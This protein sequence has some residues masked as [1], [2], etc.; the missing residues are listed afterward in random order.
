[1]K[2][3][4]ELTSDLE[5][6]LTSTLATNDVDYG[7]IDDSIRRFH[8]ATMTVAHIN[9]L[10]G[11]LDF[12]QIDD[13]VIRVK[14]INNFF[15]DFSIEV[16]IRQSSLNPFQG[17]IKSKVQQQ[18]ML[19]LVEL[20][21]L[22]QEKEFV[23]TAGYKSE[24]GLFRAISTEMNKIEVQAKKGNV[25][26]EYKY[27]LATYRGQ[28][29]NWSNEKRFTIWKLFKYIPGKD[30]TWNYFTDTPILLGMSRDWKQYKGEPFNN[31]ANEWDK[32]TPPAHY[33]SYKEF[34][35]KNNID[36][37]DVKR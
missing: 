6:V 1:M 4:P 8:F 3:I 13:N 29:W 26:L 23:Y 17:A 7:H 22:D 35:E 9:S 32:G 20:G 33:K 19:D 15:I 10:R 18:T 12:E 11:K 25:H 31:I 28:Q 24:N 37:N 2:T 14:L 5:K 27:L 34:L 30:Q 16:A 21:A 36:I